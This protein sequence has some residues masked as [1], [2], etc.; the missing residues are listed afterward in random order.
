MNFPLSPSSSSASP[1]SPLLSDDDPTT[2]N[3]KSSHQRWCRRRQLFPSCIPSFNDP[4]TSST[5]PA[6]LFP[7]FV[8]INIATMTDR[9]IIAGASREFS[10]F[11]SSAHDSPAVVQENPDVGIGLLQGKIFILSRCYFHGVVLMC[12]YISILPTIYPTFYKKHLS[13]L[14]MRYH[15]YSVDTMFT[16]SDGGH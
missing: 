7:L 4:N 15:Y 2:G 10:A 9:S 12:V 1:L 6:Y 5:R 16:K 11:V 14:G 13:F 8:I 3:K